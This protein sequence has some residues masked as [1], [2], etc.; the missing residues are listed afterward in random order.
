MWCSP[1]V[2]PSPSNFPALFVARTFVRHLVPIWPENKL[3]RP[4][5]SV[6]TLVSGASPRISPTLRSLLCKLVPSGLSSHCRTAAFLIF[7]SN[8]NRPVPI[9]VLAGLGDSAELSPNT[10][11]TVCRHQAMCL[12][13]RL[14]A[15]LERIASIAAVIGA[16]VGRQR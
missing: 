4:C 16:V 2:L 14:H 7:P 10:C 1:V 3:T 6:P 8:E 9:A 11:R 12:R 13:N 15:R 5:A